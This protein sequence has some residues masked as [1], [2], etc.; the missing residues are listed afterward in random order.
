M[1]CGRDRH[2]ERSE[3]I[4]TSFL[5]RPWIASLPSQCLHP[6]FRYTFAISPRGAPELCIYLSP[7]L[8]GVGN[9]GCPLHPRPRV[10][11]ALVESTRVTTSTPEHPAF[12]HA[13]VFFP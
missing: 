2:C 4:H 3:A 13:M 7:S 10:H 11:F 5:L 12:P 9:A 8:E 1:W 6:N